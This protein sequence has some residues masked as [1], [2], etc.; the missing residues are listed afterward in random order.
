V[1]FFKEHNIEK[2]KKK[3]N[4]ASHGELLNFQVATLKK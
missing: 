3:R 1:G 2:E 4:N